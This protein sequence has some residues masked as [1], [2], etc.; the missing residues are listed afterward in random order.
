MSKYG[1][2]GKQY[3]FSGESIFVNQEFLLSTLMATI[4][5]LKEVTGS[6]NADI[7][8]EKVAEQIY[9]QITEA[10]YGTPEE[11]TDTTGQ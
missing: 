5:V 6:E 9:G 1:Q 10:E 3:T 2:E 11:R 8:I 7:I 4:I